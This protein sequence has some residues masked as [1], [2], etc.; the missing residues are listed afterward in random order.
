MANDTC[1]SCEFNSSGNPRRSYV[2]NSLGQKQAVKYASVNDLALFEG[3]IELG[4]AEEAEHFRELVDS[5]GTGATQ[6]M[7][8]IGEKYRWPNGIVP[9]V[10]A[11]N[12]PNQ[13]RVTDAIAHWQLK[14]PLRF[15]LRTNETDYISFEI[16]NG[17]SSPVGRRG[18]KQVIHLAAG[19]LLGQTIHE[20]AHSVGMWHEQSRT[21]RD[22]YIE[23]KAAN[24]TPGYEFNFDKQTANGFD[25][26]EYDY[27]S[28]M[29]YPKNAFSKNG[30]DTIVAKG[31]QSI[32]QRSGLSDKDVA[33]VKK[34]YP[35]LAWPP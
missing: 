5:G 14:T 6:A 16:G 21:D 18:G 35:N 28:I 15:P 19:C 8:I 27:G 23:I 9:Y 33:G 7:A 12:L 1:N 30:Q 2:I 29:H 4:T 31:G 10:I 17:C 3:D 24:I 34:I 13:Q 32:G 11:P 26:G 25:I 20:I 22:N